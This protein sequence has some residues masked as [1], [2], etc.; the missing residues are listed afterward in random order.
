MSA[1]VLDP[2][3]LWALRIGLAALLAAAAAH[4]L[5]DPTRFRTVLAGYALLPRT[6]LTPAAAL[7][8]LLESGLAGALLLPPTSR[9][10]ALVAAALL[11]LYAGAMAVNLARGRRDVDCGCLGPSGRSRLHP[12][13]VVRN[14]VLVVGA[15]LAAAPAA[16]RPLGLL[17]A[18][19]VAAAAGF[20]A[21]AWGG[22]SGLLA[23]GPRLR[24]GAPR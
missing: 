14:G 10:A 23:H 3:P 9:A 7:V 22:A 12:G 4:K 19:T 15:L 8:P 16:P 6:A 21:L 18:W 24:E 13:L 5:R 1:P 2:A 20:L 17:D 11:T